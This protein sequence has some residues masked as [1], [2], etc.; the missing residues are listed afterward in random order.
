MAK[1]QGGYV[2]SIMPRLAGLH[3]TD[4]SWRFGPLGLLSGQRPGHDTTMDSKFASVATAEHAFC[5]LRA[6]ILSGEG[7]KLSMT[8]TDLADRTGLPKRQAKEAILSLVADRYGDDRRILKGTFLTKKR[9]VDWLAVFAAVVSG[10]L[11]NRAALRSNEARAI[12]SGKIDVY[13]AAEPDTEAALCAFIAIFAALFE[14]CAPPRFADVPAELIPPAFFRI[15]WICDS[16]NALPEAIAAF[17]PFFAEGDMRRAGSVLGR[18][19]RFI[20]AALVRFLVQREAGL[21]VSNRVW[22]ST[23][24]EPGLAG[25]AHA[26]DRV[27][28]GRLLPDVGP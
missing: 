27:E 16:D 6:I 19:F 9:A 2:Q 14:I 18:A 1:L 23:V 4:Q 12:V 3:A 24:R 25:V 15:L 10:A 20:E 11:A 26:F 17:A 28:T 8:S 5:L 7:P 21:Q 13:L 22:L